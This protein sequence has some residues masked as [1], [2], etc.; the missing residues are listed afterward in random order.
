MITCGIIF[1]APAWFLDIIISTCY[2]TFEHNGKQKRIIG[3]RLGNFQKV[4]W[5][6][7]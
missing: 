1:A 3:K 2:S 4:F 7:F 5:V 6:N